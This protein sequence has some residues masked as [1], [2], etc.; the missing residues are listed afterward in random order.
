VEIQS[1]LI[2]TCGGTGGHFFPGLT[3]AKAYQEQGGEVELFI[4]G[5]NAIKQTEIAAKQGIKSIVVP[6]AKIPRTIFQI[7]PFIWEFFK[8]M[9]IAR[10]ELKKFKPTTFLAM[11][12]FTSVPSALTAVLMKIPLF[13]H[14]GNAKVGKANRFLS[15]WA[16]QIATA[17]PPI[18]RGS[19]H[20]PTIHTGMPI[21]QEL[22][23]TNISKTESIISI[24]KIYNSS[25][26]PELPLILIFGGSQGAKTFN[27]HIPTSLKNLEKKFQIIHLTGIGKKVQANE[28]YR[29]H[30]F[31]LLLLETSNDMALLYSAADLII[32][33]SGGSSI[34]EI[35][36]FAKYALLIP[37]PYAAE[38]HQDD[39]S[40]Y[41]ASF[42]GASAIKDNQCK[43]EVLTPFLEDWL[44]NIE[45]FNNLAKQSSKCAKPNATLDLI[46][47][48]NM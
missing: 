48:I 1:K 19:L 23:D 18:N 42:K 39:N 40:A 11:G 47:I 35:A 5:N 6:S 15:R 46:N 12:S 21:R 45:D 31:N 9:S 24:N 10:K 16:K 33:R 30:K 2:I 25:L 43:E 14:D 28:T 36:L 32:C 7:A 44:I 37:Y 29:N 34:A 3:V 27:E 4:N 41:L 22:I 20:C 8:G 13:L 17:F 26:T 38:M